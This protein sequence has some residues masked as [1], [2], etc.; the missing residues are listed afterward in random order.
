MWSLGCLLHELHCGSK[1]FPA[2]STEGLW[3]LLQQH[4]GRSSFHCFASRGK[5][6]SRLFADTEVQHAPERGFGMRDEQLADFV[7][8][9]LIV[10]PTQRL[11]PHEALV[12]PFLSQFGH[13]ISTPRVIHSQGITQTTI[14]SR[15]LLHQLRSLSTSYCRRRAEAGRRR[16]LHNHL[17]SYFFHCLQLLVE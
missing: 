2:K 4:C 1:L 8:R 15:V 14:H 17:V 12:H 5:Y 13:C 9:C 16:N 11:T 10:D 6:F 3:Q 7:A